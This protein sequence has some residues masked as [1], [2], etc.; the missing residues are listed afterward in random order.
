MTSPSR[1]VLIPSTATPKTWS[2]LDGNCVRISDSAR[3]AGVRPDVFEFELAGYQV[4]KNWATA[5]NKSGIQRKGTTL[6]P[7]AAQLYRQ[8]LFAIQ[9]TIEL[10]AQIDQVLSGHLRFS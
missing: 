6:T 8:V 3:V 1:D 9:E 4:C 2:R 5:G 10:R 7:T